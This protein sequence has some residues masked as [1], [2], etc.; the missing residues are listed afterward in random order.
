MAYDYNKIKQQYEALSPEKQKQF[1]E[2]NKNDS[3][4]NFKKFMNQYNA[5][6]NQTTN[7]SQTT[8]TTVSKNAV[9]NNNY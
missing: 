8:G 4:G 1:A 2:M 3:T 9:S 6:K 7:T 5:E